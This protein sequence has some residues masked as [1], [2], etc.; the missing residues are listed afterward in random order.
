MKGD[1]DFPKSVVVTCVRV[2]KITDCVNEVRPF[3]FIVPRT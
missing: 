3:P 1:A 2:S